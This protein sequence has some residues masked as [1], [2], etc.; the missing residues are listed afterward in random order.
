MFM[1]MMII[2]SIW[3]IIEIIDLLLGNFVQL[4]NVERDQRC[5]KYE[6]KAKTI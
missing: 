4:I 3:E 5:R 2:G 1:M 6:V